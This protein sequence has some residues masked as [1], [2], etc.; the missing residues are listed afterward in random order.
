MKVTV[1]KN[2]EGWRVRDALPPELRQRVPSTLAKEDR[3]TVILFPHA[4]EDVVRSPEVLKALR[5]LALDERVVGVGGTF[6]AEARAALSERGA[7]I[8]SM[9]D[10]FWTDESYVAIK[11]PAPPRSPRGR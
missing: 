3:Y 6:T 1:T 9:G 11:T 2:V 10:Y 4:R 8:V 7:I 5:K